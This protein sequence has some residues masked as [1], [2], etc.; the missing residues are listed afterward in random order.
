MAADR[1]CSR[2]C[3]KVDFLRHSLNAGRGLSCDI[4]CRLAEAGA[5]MKIRVSED[6]GAGLMFLGFGAT[7]AFGAARY[8]IGTPA[9]MGPGFLPL[10]AGLFVSVIG[11]ILV[12]RSVFASSERIDLYLVPLAILSLAICIFA[13]S[14]PYLGLVVA[15]F[16]LTVLSARASPEF[17][18]AGAS[19][20]GIVIAAISLALFIC[21]LGLPFNAWPPGIRW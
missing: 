7:F 11:L 4:A 16:L 5:R 9:E 6:L 3:F 13:L 2:P 1:R 8:T 14:F 12:G 10:Y 15:T 18:V 21:G 19:L 17:S 20:V